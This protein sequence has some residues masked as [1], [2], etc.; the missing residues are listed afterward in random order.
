MLEAV[1]DELVDRQPQGGGLVG[2]DD[3]ATISDKVR[4]T[5][6][7]VEDDRNRQPGTASGRTEPER[8]A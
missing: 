6:V 8:G 4:R 7:E 3:D 1:G 2:G 5:E